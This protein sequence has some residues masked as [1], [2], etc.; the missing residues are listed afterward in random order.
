MNV[1]FQ[2]PDV[3]VCFEKNVAAVAK[4]VGIPDGEHDVYALMGVYEWFRAID[5]LDGGQTAK[6][7]EIMVRML[8]QELRPGLRSFLAS[9]TDSSLDW[10]TD[11]KRRLSELAGEKFE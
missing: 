5:A 3:Q 1:K 4:M 2:H 6:L 9:R 7:E 10:F 11:F 8:S